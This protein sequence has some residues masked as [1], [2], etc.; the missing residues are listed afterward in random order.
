MGGIFQ[1]FLNALKAIFL[2]PFYVVYFAFYLV[3]SLI[4]HLLGELKVLFSGFRYGH[5]Q[6]NKYTKKVQYII[7][8]A[9]GK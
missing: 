1:F 6:E 9:G 7:K 5:K 8:K 3:G 4:N 2:G